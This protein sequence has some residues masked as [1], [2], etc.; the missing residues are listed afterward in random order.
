MEWSARLGRVGSIDALIDSLA[1]AQTP[2]KRRA[3]RG[4]GAGTKRGGTNSNWCS[5]P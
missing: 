3:L 5:I 2:P 4:M 1:G